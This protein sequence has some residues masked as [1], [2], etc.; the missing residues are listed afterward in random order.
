MKLVKKEQIKNFTFDCKKNF[1]LISL[2]ENSY[3]IWPIISINL[4]YYLVKTKLG[5]NTRRQEIP[6]V[7][8]YNGAIYVIPIKALMNKKTSKFTIV[9]KSIRTYGNSLS[10]DT[11]FE[12]D[13]EMMIRK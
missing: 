10:V 2:F 1:P 11:T 5:Y 6:I 8:E 13:F 4:F 3:Q 12:P 7:Y 9:N